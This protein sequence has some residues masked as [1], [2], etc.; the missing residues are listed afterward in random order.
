MNPND[1][2]TASAK[3]HCK[4][5]ENLERVVL[6]FGIFMRRQAYRGLDT[7]EEDGQ[8]LLD[9]PLSDL[10]VL[11]QIPKVREIAELLADIINYSDPFIDELRAALEATDG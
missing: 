8:A 1:T 2:K 11:V 5:P 6:E 4:K 3:V 10:S 9:G 7:Y